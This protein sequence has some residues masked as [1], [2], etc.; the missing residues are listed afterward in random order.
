MPEQSA[1]ETAVAA[2]EATGDFRLL[3]RLR[4]EDLS[5]VASPSFTDLRVVALDVETTGLDP[6]RDRIIELAARAFWAE[7]QTCEVIN[8][9]PPYTWLEDPGQPLSQTITALTGLTDADLV[10]HA[11]DE[12]AASRL[13]LSADLIVAHHA[14]FDRP[15]VERRLPAVAGRR[16]GCSCV[17]VDWRG[18]G[19]EGRA[20][21][22]LLAQAGHF[23]SDRSHRAGVDVDALI[24]LLAHRLPS[25][26][27]VLKELVETASRPTLRF[28]AVGAHFDVKDELKAHGYAWDS[29]ERVWQREIAIDHADDERAWLAEHVYAPAHRPRMA[30]PAVTEVTWNTR[31]AG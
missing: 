26:A 17:E 18:H 14:V 19:F 23:Q 12:R 22:W 15:F 20:L 11:I 21:G 8:V 31:H 24:G 10:G 25:G 13:L 3:R 16:W 9:E 30:A 5:S 28:R 29:A 4:V 27:T 2:I 7:P 1:I 6:T